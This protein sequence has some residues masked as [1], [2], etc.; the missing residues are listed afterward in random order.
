MNI[1]IFILC[2]NES[3]LLPHTIN[4]YRKYLPNAKITI[5]DNE[6]TDN[7]V[8]IAKSMNCKV[9]PFNSNNEQNEFSQRHIKDNCWKNVTD[10]WILMLDMD[11]WLCITE[12]ELIDEQK[13]GTTILKIQGVEMLGESQTLDLKDIDLH[14]IKKGL[15]FELES[16]SLCFY[17][18]EIQEMKYGLGAH[19][20]HPEGNIKY[21]SKVY[22][23]K[24]LRNLG[25]PFIIDKTQKRYL[26]TNLMR[27]QGYDIHYTDDISKITNEYNTLFENAKEYDW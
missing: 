25:L 11:E 12:E 3:L 2:Y 16:K 17:R 5:Y 7:S 9:I 24:H 15:D 10:G 26:R 14:S 27:S 21:S 1:N 18:N 19:Y 23:N 6:S 13:N 8:E 4:H 20:C 22:I